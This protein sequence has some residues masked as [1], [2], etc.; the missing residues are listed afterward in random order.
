MAE[1]IAI[2]PR[3]EAGAGSTRDQEHRSNLGVP[4]GVEAIAQIKTNTSGLVGPMRIG[5]S[6][7]ADPRNKG[8]VMLAG[9]DARVR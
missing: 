1:L 4:A 7:K 2:L 5:Q 9:L 8:H 6:R 3:S